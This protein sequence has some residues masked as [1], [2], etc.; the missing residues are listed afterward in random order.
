[1]SIP[2]PGCATSLSF[3]RQLNGVFEMRSPSSQTAFS[4]CLNSET[5]RRGPCSSTTTLCPRV[6]SSLASTPPAAPEPTITKSTVSEG[7]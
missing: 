6:E 2:A 1:M 4:S 5:P 7:A 3:W